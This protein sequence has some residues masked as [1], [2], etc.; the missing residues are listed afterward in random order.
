MPEAQPLAVRLAV[1]TDKFNQALGELQ[2]FAISHLEER[3]DESRAMLD[4]VTEQ[5]VTPDGKED[6]SLCADLSGT[7]SERAEQMMN[8]HAYHAATTDVLNTKYRQKVIRDAPRPTPHAQS[9]GLNTMYSALLEAT[10]HATIPEAL[11]SLPTGAF[12]ATGEGGLLLPGLEK[13][14]FPRFDDGSPRLASIDNMAALAQLQNVLATTSTL[15]EAAVRGPLE[16][17]SILDQDYLAPRFRSTPAE[18]NASSITLPITGTIVNAAAERAEGAAAAEASIPAST[19]TFTLIHLSVTVPVTDESLMF[20]TYTIELFNYELPMMLREEL[21][22]Y[23]W[24]T[25]DGNTSVLSQDV[26]V[27]SG[28]P[29]DGYNDIKRAATKMYE[30]ARLRA[31]IVALP[32]STWDE[33]LFAMAGTNSYWVDPRV[34]ERPRIYG[35]PVFTPIGLFDALGAANNTLGLVAHTARYNRFWT[36]EGI[37]VEQGMVADQFKEYKRS[38]RAGLRTCFIITQPQAFV[39]LNQKA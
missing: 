4:R 11:A 35:L 34:M 26:T 2:G 9:S 15:E 32:P 20:R 18:A 19:E 3:F 22:K 6:L 21:D 10:N 31:A 24:R 5:M 17:L 16:I 28:K 23:M 33:I 27:T 7:L 39:K 8:L 30:Q 25:I 37:R 13:T 14:L 36:R 29:T 38:F 12:S 1:P